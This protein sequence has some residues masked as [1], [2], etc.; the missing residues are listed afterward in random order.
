MEISKGD[1]KLIIMTGKFLA[2]KGYHKEDVAIL[3]LDNMKIN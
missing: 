2:G 3:L 1:E